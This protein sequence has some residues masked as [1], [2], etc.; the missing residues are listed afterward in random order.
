MPRFIALLLF[1]SIAVSGCARSGAPGAPP[2]PEMKPITITDGG[3][4]ALTL[5]TAPLE[6]AH[7]LVVRD[8][9][10]ETVWTA[11]GAGEEGWLLEAERLTPD[12]L[13]LRI[14]HPDF[15]RETYRVEI[16]VARDQVVFDMAHEDPSRGF[17]WLNYPPKF[18]APLR[19]GRLLFS[20]RSAGILLP[21]DEPGFYAGRALLALGN[22]NALDLPMIA[23][24]E[25]RTGGGMY[26][27]YD[28]P[29]DVLARIEVDGAGL[30][31]PQTIWVRE[32]GKWGYDRRA[33]VGFVPSGGYVAIA[34]RYREDAA[35]S[36]FMGPTLR[37]KAEARPLVDWLAGAPIV[38]QS[39]GVRFAREARARGMRRAL[40]SNRFAP[41][42]MRILEAMEF[43]TSEYDNYSDLVPSDA[44]DAQP[45]ER[46][47]AALVLSDGRLAKGWLS[48][49][50]LQ[51]YARSHAFAEAMARHLMPGI[52]AEFP[53][54]ARFIDV[55]AGLQLQEDYNPERPHGRRADRVF[56]T[57]LFQYMTDELGLVL[58]GEHVNAWAVPYN[59]YS[60]GT[61]S[62]GFWWETPVGHLQRLESMDEVSENYIRY[63]LDPAR[64]VP[65]YDL[66]FRDR[67]VST[68]Y[69]GDSNGYL[70]NIWP[71]LSDWKDAA[72]ILHGAPP[73][74]WAGELCF[75]WDRERRRFLHTVRTTA[76]W[77]AA[78][79]YDEMVDH[80]VDR[81]APE[82]HRTLFSSGARV[83]ANLGE[84]PRRVEFD[85][86][87]VELAPHGYAAEAEGI[88]LRRTMRQGAV[89]THVESQDSYLFVDQDAVLR[90]GPARGAGTLA[91]FSFDEGVWN[92]H[93][94][95][96]WTID[97]AEVPGWRQPASD[98]R[99]F[100]ADTFG[101]P[102]R[103]IEA[104]RSGLLEV[105]GGEDEDGKLFVLKTDLP[106]EHPVFKPSGG[107]MAGGTKVRLSAPG[108]SEI[109]ITLDG[110]EPTPASALYTGPI[111]LAR[112]M[113][114]RARAFRDGR[115]Q[116][117]E[118]VAEYSVVHELK[119]VFHAGGMDARPLDLDVRGA[120]Q[121]RI[122]VT[123]AGDG[124]D[125]DSFLMGD[126]RGI[127]ADGQE[128]P[129]EAM[130]IARAYQSS[131]TMPV[132]DLRD[133]E[134]GGREFD[135]GMFMHA[136]GELWFQIDGRFDRI[137][138]WFGNE[139][140]E[141]QS[142]I[143]VFFSV[144][145]E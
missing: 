110:S 59:D 25:G 41:D 119:R 44:P 115:P 72:N 31:W 133:V 21:Q 51:Y 101:Q 145:Y 140:P 126:M 10:A 111:E 143:E 104:P 103:E 68:W 109:R 27:A 98:L 83:V 94:R 92:A 79:M 96:A 40:L 125:F 135:T 11:R 6:S 118:V 19:D 107:E 75:G 52:L 32:I 66:V 18:T 26:L 116:S 95:G 82:I 4:L 54:T 120:R 70:H 5:S 37:E 102:V 132:V 129:L 42:D 48:I 8:D 77:Q 64:R 63:S 97:L 76:P 15:P 88:R 34:K 45:F 22:T 138:G 78:I 2:I 62:G 56:R 60:E 99:L 39:D 3:P 57:R 1:L 100:E 30:A 86:A 38:W 67:I 127:T 139:Q 55:S 91:F 131:P 16:A 141:G 113:T 7:Y 43:L 12:R 20:D 47:D 122:L 106:L 71:E 105:D 73:M 112:A 80:R 142:T 89:V 136:R 49:H 29:E 65:L 128:V 61:L 14:Q 81:G 24:V 36:G 130:P 23:V 46:L 93:A 74:L 124:T 84:E 69:W 35:R 9:R 117:D 58:G 134:F 85:G 53:F 28:T 114:I 121:F 87:E 123:D 50:G 90:T 108:A 13:R 33:R 137:V 144:L 17:E